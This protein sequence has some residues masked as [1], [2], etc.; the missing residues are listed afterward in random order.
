M[1]ELYPFYFLFFA[2]GTVFGSFLN[3]VS[4]RIVSGSSILFGRSV[5]DYCRNPLNPKNLIPLLSYF[6]QR[7]KSACCK[8]SL[9]WSYPISEFMTG[10]AF[11]F[12]AYYSKVLINFNFSTL[13]VCLYLLSV[14]SFFIILFFSDAKYRLLPDKIVYT[15]IFVTLL[16]ILTLYLVDLKIYH[17]KLLVG[18]FGQYLIKAGFW[19]NH[20]F[21]VLKQ[22]M[23]LIASS[24]FISFFFMTLIFITKGRGMGGG[25][26]KLGFLIGLFNGFPGNVLAIF[27]GFLFGSLYSLLLISLKRKS[28]KDT[29]AF[30]PFLILGSI[31]AFVWG[32]Q[33]IKWYLGFM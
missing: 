6:M 23:V 31:V 12:S 20:L 15:A 28:I 19:K 26:V 33:I 14:L 13:L 18:T 5:C 17:D 11:L 27:L 29:I 1:I 24:F 8:K 7:G 2:F 3:L 32:E 25:D 4:D 10:S 22:F 21:L 16:F 9:S 30:G